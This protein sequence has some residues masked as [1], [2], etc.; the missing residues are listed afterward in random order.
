ML[1]SDNYE[2]LK[3]WHVIYHWKGNFV[4]IQLVNKTH[5]WKFILYS[6][7][8]HWGCNVEMISIIIFISSPENKT[9]II[10]WP[11]CIHFGFTTVLFSTDNIVCTQLSLYIQVHG[12]WIK[13][14][15][16]SDMASHLL[17]T[18]IHLDLPSP[19]LARSSFTD[20]LTDRL[21]PVKL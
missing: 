20:G 4:L 7:M 12:L 16:R 2:F 8:L 1:I 18:L 15:C 5:A 14:Q 11:A 17:Q 9:V 3:T 10:S 19:L 6:Q 13:G 21:T